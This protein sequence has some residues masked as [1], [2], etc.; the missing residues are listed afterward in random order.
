M[1]RNSVRGVIIGSATFKSTMNQFFQPYLRSFVLVFYDGILV[2]SCGWEEHMD[3]LSRV[4]QL[5]QVN[6]F[7]VNKKCTFGSCQVECLGHRFSKFGVPVD[8]EKIK[9]IVE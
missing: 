5:L 6:N 3:R 4:L 8:L 9:S 7:V 2:C 1:T